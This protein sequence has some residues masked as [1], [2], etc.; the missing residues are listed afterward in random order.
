MRP[1]TRICP[2]TVMRLT[3]WLG[4]RSGTRFRRR[5]LGG[6]ADGG[7]LLAFLCCRPVAASVAV[8]PESRPAT[9]TNG[10]YAVPGQRS[11]A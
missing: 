2:V 4:G 5:C 3:P 8:A 11:P 1:T 10:A 9:L 7:V 6:P